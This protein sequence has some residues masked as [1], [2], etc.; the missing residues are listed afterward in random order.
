MEAAIG[1]RWMI[2]CLVGCVDSRLSNCRL[3]ASLATSAFLSEPKQLAREIKRSIST[4]FDEWSLF[5]SNRVV[6]APLLLHQR[7]IDEKA[8]ARK[9]AKG[10]AHQLYSLLTRCTQPHNARTTNETSHRTLQSAKSHSFHK[11]AWSILEIPRFE[12]E[13]P[14]GKIVISHEYT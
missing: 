13:T 1:F 10:Q 7:G 12:H 5:I 8:H 2:P 6:E 4:K 11:V 14:H 3:R 9:Q